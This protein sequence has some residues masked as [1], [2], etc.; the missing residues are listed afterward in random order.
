MLTKNRL[1]RINRTAEDPIMDESSGNGPGEGDKIEPPA[2]TSSSAGSD[3]NLPVVWSPQLGAGE[4]FADASPHAEQAAAS[5][6]D[7]APG[8][9]AGEAA[10]PAAPPRSWRFAL[11]A[12]AVALAA[13]IG[14]LIGGMGASG[15]ARL[16]PAPA[17]APTLADASGV[18]HAMKAELAELTALKASLDGAART[19]SS[20]FATIADRLDRVE[21]TTADPAAAA[22]L[23]HIAEVVDRLDKLNAL[24]ETTG[25]IGSS[26]PPAA[27][28][29]PAPPSAPAAD[30][31]I[32]DRIV[33]DWVVQDVRGD[34][35]LVESRFGGVFVVGAGSTLPGLGHVDAVKR[36]DGQWIVVTERGTITSGR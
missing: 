36:Q 8:D 15:L 6:H 25:S 27:S 12:A 28:A 32:I 2:A 26:A 33:P 14:S 31:K 11:L 19:S 20:Q 23:A 7:E 24:P 16:V 17:P 9:T 22:K 34:R 1:R 4:E 10:S 30:A 21:R 29:A 18:V 3:A 35:A 5:P 13:G